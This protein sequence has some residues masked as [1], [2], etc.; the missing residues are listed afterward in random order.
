MIYPYI[1]VSARKYIDVTNNLVIEYPKMILFSSGE[2]VAE[3]LEP[4]PIA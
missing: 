4:V 2:L 1:R 3:G